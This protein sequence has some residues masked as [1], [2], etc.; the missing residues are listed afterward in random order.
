MPLTR[1]R[2]RTDRHRPTCQSE[3]PHTRSPFFFFLP[4][5]TCGQ[6]ASVKGILWLV[7]LVLLLPIPATAQTTEQQATVLHL[8]QTAERKVMRDFLRIELRV[9]ETGA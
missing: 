1:L 3:I 9:E 5:P 4:D 8:S 7:A 2:A 6:R